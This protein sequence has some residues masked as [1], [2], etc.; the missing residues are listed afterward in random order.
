VASNN[1]TVSLIQSAT[2]WHDPAANRELFD[3]W[4]VQVPQ[5]AEI[6]LL[7]EMF[8][9]GFTMASAEQAETMDG[10]TV[11]W[12]I[13]AARVSGKTLCGSIVV[14]LPA[15]DSAP[16]YVNRLL[17]V[18]PEGE[19][20]TYDKRHRFRMA[21]EHLHYAAGQERVVVTHKGVRILLQVC[22]DL[23]FPVFARNRCDYDVYLLVANWPAARQHHWNT[24]LAA[25]AIENQCY[26]VAVNRVGEDG[27][28]VVYGGGSGIYNYQGEADVLSFETEEVLSGQL[29]LAAQ[30]SYRKAFPAWQDADEFQ[31]E[32]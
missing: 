7:P 18:T 8:S 1:V 23:R 15:A 25:R 6:V 17:W 32:P 4:L 26:V 30:A 13:A 11:S 27:N 14:A 19:V 9:T 16:Q 20:T 28:G 22:Y 21:D 3:N 29:D 5:E 31:L 2:H 10:P 12:L 24:L